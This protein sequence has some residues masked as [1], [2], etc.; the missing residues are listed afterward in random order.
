MK[1]LLL[2]TALLFAIT[3]QAQADY[4]TDCTRPAGMVLDG[5]ILYFADSGDGSNNGKISK[6][7]I[8]QV[9]P[10]RVDIVTGLEYPRA[11]ALQG[12]DLYL[13]TLSGALYTID[14]TQTNP[15]PVFL[16]NVTANSTINTRTTYMTLHNGFL[17]TALLDG[18]KVIRI[19]LTNPTT[20][21]DM[22]TGLQ[23]PHATAHIGDDLYF[24]D[25]ISGNGT[26]LFKINITDTNPTP[27]IVENTLAFGNDIFA[28]GTDIYTIHGGSAQR[29][30]K[31]DTTASLPT[32]EE[33]VY[34]G[35]DANSV[36]FLI[37]G[38][39]FYISTFQTPGGRIQKYTTTVL[40][41]SDDKLTTGIAVYPNPVTT[42]VTVSLENDELIKEVSVFNA[43]G[44]K[45]KEIQVNTT[46]KATVDV[47]N[48]SKG[49]YFLN[50]K[51]ES[52]TFT[53]K[54]M[55]H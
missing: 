1:K 13:L 34:T 11:L 46:S 28:V 55:K 17:Y 50:V 20:S 18:G 39:D 23:F 5:N 49:I 35:I 4:F 32:F 24:T 47:S 45:V 40:G 52:K 7:D 31:T 6:I 37:T 44:M 26:R 48:L 19:P 41:V 2:L 21:E 22:V 42:E 16:Q 9:T 10:T 38:N 25:F 3:I 27:V 43:L 53:K 54:I 51:S 8:S 36:N 12:T 33:T 29:I 30:T 15:T 14:L